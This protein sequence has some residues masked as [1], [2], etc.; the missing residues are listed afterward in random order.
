MMNKK[1]L[2]MLLSSI[3]LI[4]VVGVGATLAYFT[5]STET[6]SNIITTGNVNITI[7]ENK[8]ELAEDGV[9]YELTD[10]VVSL[11]DEVKGVSYGNIMPGQTL[12]KNPTISLQGDSR[13]A[14]VRATVTVVPDVD[15]EEPTADDLAYEANLANLQSQLITSITGTGDW[16]LGVG[17]KLY[18]QD[19]LTK[20]NA[21]KLFDT[22]VIP[23]TWANNS[24]GRTFS[25]RIQ[26]EAVQADYLE[27]SVLNPEAEISRWDGI[28]TE[29]AN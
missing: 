26:A 10:E 5:D 18:F 28:T 7:S 13:D 4:A 11:E 3:A 6:M 23:T 17:G 29:E 25:I 1:K 2:I 19:I 8:V 20:D 22:V 21:A 12:P 27:A 15:I 14:Y 24:S 9:E 16:V